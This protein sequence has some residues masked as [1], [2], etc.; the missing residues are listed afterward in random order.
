MFGWRPG[1]VLLILRK[2]IH[3]HRYKEIKESDQK[4]PSQARK[5]RLTCSF[6]IIIIII[7]GRLRVLWEDLRCLR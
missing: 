5:R 1:S 2:Q 3:Q 4:D 6:Q 7:I